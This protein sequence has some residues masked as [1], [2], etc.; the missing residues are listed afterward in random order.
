MTVMYS[1]LNRDSVQDI[2]IEY[3]KYWGQE[4]DPHWHIILPDIHV[5][6]VK[7]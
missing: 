5:H 3:Q 4:I 6:N 2:K 7:P 1:M